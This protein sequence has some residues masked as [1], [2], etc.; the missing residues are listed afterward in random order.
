MNNFINK[1][2]QNNLETGL[3]K[4]LDDFSL[5]CGEEGSLEE[6]RVNTFKD[7]S[8]GIHS[9]NEITHLKHCQN[10]KTLKYIV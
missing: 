1:A 3:M 2:D 7:L 10:F 6:S 5:N 9:N 4:L 8:L